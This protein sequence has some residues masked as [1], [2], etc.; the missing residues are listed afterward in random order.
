MEKT[1]LTE[2]ITIKMAETMY[3][4]EKVEEQKKL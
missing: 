1:L 4:A 3:S 2:A